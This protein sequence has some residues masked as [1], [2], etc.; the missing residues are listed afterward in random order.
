M[1]EL[2]GQRGHVVAGSPRSAAG[3]T[4]CDRFPVDADLLIRPDVPAALR[5]SPFH[6]HTMKVKEHA[7][8]VCYIVSI[9]DVVATIVCVPGQDVHANTGGDM[10]KQNVDPGDRAVP[11]PRSSYVPPLEFA[12][13]VKLKRAS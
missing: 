13:V 9:R 8:I 3:Q 12:E 10:R 5:S 6:Q 2:R 7:P 4:L 11:E 1:S